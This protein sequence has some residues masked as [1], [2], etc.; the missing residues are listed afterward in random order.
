MLQSFTTKAA[1][2]IER[3]RQWCA[4]TRAEHVEFSDDREASIRGG[5]F[6]HLR[7][8]LVSMG[9]HHVTQSRMA[10]FA[11]PEP[12]LKLLFQESGQTTISQGGL[13]T[14]LQA[15]QWCAIRK[16]IPFE[17]EAPKPSRQLSLTLRCGVVPNPGRGIAWWRKPRNFLSGPAQILHASASASIMSGDSLTELDCAQLGGQLA[18]MI[19]ITL[20]SEGE[21]ILPDIREKRRRAILEFIDRNLAEPGLGVE[22]IAREFSC[23]SRTI[24]KLFEGQ[25]HT[26]VRAIWER[27]LER[28]RDE[29]IDPVMNGQSITQIA[30][31]WGF[32]DSQ[33]FSRAFKTRFSITPREYRALHSVS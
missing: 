22:Q 3:S 13:G 11:S 1:N 16:D 6:G 10:E 31:L 23:S 25:A 2:R 14:P 29:M 24:H 19:E 28:C 30:H 4:L 26:V 32:S 8:C 12:T 21:G 18:Q 15:G 7:L 5:D 9:S 27:R 33:H 17:I 20:R